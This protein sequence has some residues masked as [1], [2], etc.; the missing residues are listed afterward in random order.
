MT[1]SQ[2]NVEKKELLIERRKK[3]LDR[4]ELDNINAV[5]RLEKI[6]VNVGVGD[7]SENVNKMDEIEETL[8]LITGQRPQITRARKSVANFGVRQGDPMGY[9]VTLRERKMIDFLRKIVHLVL[10]RTKDFRGLNP[11]SFDGRGNYSF[12]LNE[13]GV[14]PEISYEEIGT[15]FGMDITIV[16]S[17]EDT[18]EAKALLEEYGFPFA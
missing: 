17:T 6:V 9:K 1:A 18:E 3:L 16:T 11:G 14:F 8:T 4:L 5:P 15:V 12:G 7:A 13:Q 10:P 2:V